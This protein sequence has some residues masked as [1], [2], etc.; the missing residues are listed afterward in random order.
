LKSEDELAIAESKIIWKW[1][2]IPKSL[3]SLI[4]EKPGNFR[5]RKFVSSRNSMPNSIERS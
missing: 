3:S 1:K 5:N 4:V 2:K